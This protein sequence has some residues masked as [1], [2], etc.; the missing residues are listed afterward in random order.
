M[1]K[2][3]VD[4][5]I[6]DLDNTLCEGRVAQGIGKSY[7][8]REL[9]RGNF[10]TFSEGWKG[11]KR[12]RAVVKA[13]GV[14]GEAEGLRE[15][16]AVLTSLG[17]GEKHEM[18]RFAR[19]YVGDYAIREVQAFMKDV[20]NGTPKILSTVGGS[21]AAIAAGTYF[22]IAHTVSNKDLFSPDGRLSGVKLLIRNGEEKLSATEELLEQMNIR[23]SRCVVI[24]DSAV[25]IPLLKAA[26][27]GYASPF[28][29]EEV[30][31]VPGVTQLRML[32]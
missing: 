27:L 20:A 31:N 17:V 1:R 30:R 21:T 24:G 11:A 19:K 16:Y 6:A 32:Y 22:G 10:D 5:L 18:Y 8:V 29:T 9:L 26:G 2:L 25:D 14:N 12:V 7:L 23:L 4:A 3:K 13:A 28:A 15:F